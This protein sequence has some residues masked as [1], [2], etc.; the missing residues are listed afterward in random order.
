M[1]FCP[2]K[3]FRNIL[4]TPGKGAHKYKLFNTAIV[5]YALSLLGAVLITYLTAVPLVLTTIGVLIAGI[6]LHV[7]FG[8]NTNT[9]QYLGIRCS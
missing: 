6:I 1:D 8:V 9:L 5:D 4:G 2:F 7:L 3:Q